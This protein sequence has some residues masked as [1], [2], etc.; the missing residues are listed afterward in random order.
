MK[1]L[2]ANYLFAIFKIVTKETESIF[3]FA[4][5]HEGCRKIILVNVMQE[6]CKMCI[7]FGFKTSY[8]YTLH[9]TCVGKIHVVNSYIN[10]ILF[11][12]FLN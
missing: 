7:K 12:V 1:F 8:M 6:N 10:V 9:Y 11:H 2:A 4:Y 3:L 5:L